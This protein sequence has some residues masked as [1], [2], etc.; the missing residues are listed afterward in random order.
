MISKE[1][2]INKARA[3]ASANDYFWSEEDIRTELRNAVPPS[4]SWWKRTFLKQSFRESGAG[5]PECWMV[6]VG[7]ILLTSE[8]IDRGY[9]PILGEGYGYLFDVETGAFVGVDVG[10]TAI[11]K[12]YCNI[13]EP[14]TPA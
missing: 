9:L 1:F 10:D 6:R 5:F 11:L 12:E 14:D 13:K 8:W 3:I 7:K 4:T 2:A